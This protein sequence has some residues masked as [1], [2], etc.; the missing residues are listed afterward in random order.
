MNSALSLLSTAR[1][2][3]AG[4][5]CLLG[6]TIVKD[7]DI[8]SQAQLANLKPASFQF[9]QSTNNGGESIV[10]PITLDNQGRITSIDVPALGN[11]K[12]KYKSGL[13]GPVT[14][15]VGYDSITGKITG[16]G[17]RLTSS[18]NYTERYRF[19]YDQ[20]ARL[21]KIVTN[22]YFGLD[23]LHRGD[24]LIYSPDGSLASM[25]RNVPDSASLSGPIGLT[26]SSNELHDITYLSKALNSAL[27]NCPT[28]V[29]HNECGGFTQPTGSGGNA[30]GMN[31]HFT[32]VPSLHQVSLID[33]RNPNNGGGG[34]NGCGRDLDTYYFHPLMIFTEQFVLGHDL[35]MIYAIDWWIPGTAVTS[36]N[37]NQ[38]DIVTFK[39]NYGI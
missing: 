7:T 9:V 36:T 33:L 21:S 15:E 2:A 12:L 23:T 16:V 39:I 19:R 37:F 29:S 24:T 25:Y 35:L 27:G 18:S 20:N 14:I 3:I 32:D 13:K 22:I 38:D 11:Y 28:G 26:Y 5:F 31:Y 6:C 34:C 1:L 17:V 30:P 10:A 8:T 4:T